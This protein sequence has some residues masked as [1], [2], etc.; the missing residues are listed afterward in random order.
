MNSQTALKR[1]PKK[2]STMGRVRNKA[3][4]GR[5]ADQASVGWPPNEESTTMMK[6]KAVLIGLPLAIGLAS[7]AAAETDMQKALADGAQRM[8][9]DEIAERLADKTVTFERAGSGDRW[10]VYYDGANGTRIQKVGSDKVSEGFYAVSSAD[11]VCFGF[12]GGEPMRLRC[13]NVLLVDGQMS[14]FELDGSLR[15]RI[16]DEVNGNTS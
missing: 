1:L 13:V 11:H 2:P 16:V 14:K 8:T 4:K 6:S 9:A 10:F 15:G 5:A 3:C 12:K 7:T